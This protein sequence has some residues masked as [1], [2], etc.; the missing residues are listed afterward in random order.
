GAG[1]QVTAVAMDAHTVFALA[2][3]HRADFDFFDAGGI[4]GPGL[5]FVHLLVGVDEDFLGVLRV[6]DVIAGETANKPFAEFDD[7]IF[8]SVDGLDPDAIGGSA[9]RFA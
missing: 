2:G 4:N 5:G 9:V 7:F 8:S 3:E 6:D 1:G